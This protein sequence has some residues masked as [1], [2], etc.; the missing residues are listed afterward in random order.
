MYNKY[1]VWMTQG[2]G[3]GAPEAE[4]ETLEEAV[5]EARGMWGEGCVAIEKPDG[6]YHEFDEEFGHES[7][8]LPMMVLLRLR[9]GP[10]NPR[11]KH[12]MKKLSDER[13]RLVIRQLTEGVMNPAQLL[14]EM[15]QAFCLGY[16]YMRVCD[17]HDLF[18]E[19]LTWGLF[20]AFEHRAGSP[21]P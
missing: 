10:L 15:E 16:P 12:L 18:L 11:Q 6:T 17:I 7:D 4:C 9:K 14:D 8:K 1:K 20:E 19:A 3:F 2:Q 21:Y 13:M 5:D